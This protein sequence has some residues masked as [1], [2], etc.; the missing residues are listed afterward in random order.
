M[1][2]FKSTKEDLQEFFGL[3]FGS[4]EEVPARAEQMRSG[5]YKVGGMLGV[6]LILLSF[7][8]LKFTN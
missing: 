7:L 1:A 2:K 8:L 3:V 5:I 4:D 6:G